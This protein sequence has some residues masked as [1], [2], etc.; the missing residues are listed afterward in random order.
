MWV[1]LHWTH[2]F[3]ALLPWEKKSA[4]EKT[5]CTV[6]YVIS[7]REGW[8]GFRKP[9]C[10]DP[11]HRI[12]F[13]EIYSIKT[14]NTDG[15]II[16]VPSKVWWNMFSVTSERKLENIETVNLWLTMV[17]L[18]TAF[19][20]FFSLIWGRRH[21]RRLRSFREGVFI[22]S[23]LLWPGNSVSTEGSSCL[24]RRLPQVMVT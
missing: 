16:K 11:E 22:V 10:S 9:Q 23:Y 4:Q 20:H 3:P 5:M 8:Y 2:L 19:T 18:Y 12:T 21:F 24:I 6:Y 13:C 14:N 15:Y 1:C 17:W 7:F